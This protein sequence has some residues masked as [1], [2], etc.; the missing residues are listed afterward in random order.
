M[1]RTCFLLLAAIT[2][3]SIGLAAQRGSET[4]APS[5]KLLGTWSGSWDGGG[6]GGGFELTLERDKNGAITGKVSVTG[7]PTYKATFKSLSFDGMKM[8]AKYDFPP[9]DAAE[10]VLAATFEG[11]SASGTWS[12][13]EK[14]TGNEAASGGWK[15]TRHGSK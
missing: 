11:D 5:D 10:V 4:P 9:E 13:R 7:E 2:L 12:L 8:S 3:A 14:A 15:V 1:R 6:S